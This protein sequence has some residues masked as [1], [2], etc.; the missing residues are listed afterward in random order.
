[1]HREEG[2]YGNVLQVVLAD[3]HKVGGNRLAAPGEECG[4]PCTGRIWQ[5]CYM[6]FRGSPDPEFGFGFGVL[7]SVVGL[8]GA[9]ASRSLCR[10]DFRVRYLVTGRGHT[11]GCNG[12]VGK[13]TKG[14]DDEQR[15]NVEE[16]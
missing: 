11:A 4:Y 14:V 5:C 15:S 1:M 6:L 2:K 12:E 8:D 7:E 3:G 16:F 9:S 10:L 13:R